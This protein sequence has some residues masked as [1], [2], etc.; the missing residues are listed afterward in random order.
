MAATLV[1]EDVVP[2]SRNLNYWD[3]VSTLAGEVQNPSRTFP[4]ALGMGVVTVMLG[5]LVPVLVGLGVVGF[6]AF[7]S[8]FAR[9]GSRVRTWQLP[10]ISCY[11]YWAGSEYVVHCK[12]RSVCHLLDPWNE[13]C[14]NSFVVYEAG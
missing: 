6:E 2:N 5:Y 12:S 8:N 3:S 1:P 4:R 7:P 13:C 14:A 9:L 10:V 11:C